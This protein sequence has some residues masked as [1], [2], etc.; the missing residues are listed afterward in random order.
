MDTAKVKTPD[1]FLG[2][3]SS[4]KRKRHTSIACECCR[5]LKVKCLGGEAAALSSGSATPK[6]CNHCVSQSKLC[7]WP[8][9]DGRKKAKT[10]SPA[11]SD[12]SFKSGRRVAGIPEQQ[13]SIPGVP[14]QDSAK[15]ED[16]KTSRSPETSTKFKPPPLAG[17]AK[18]HSSGERSN[19]DASQTPYVVRILLLN[20]NFQ[21]GMGE[22][23]LQARSCGRSGKF[24][25]SRERCC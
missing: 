25:A 14:R 17:N 1:D 7:V 2:P 3:P 16:T 20:D 22:R 12:V 10:S 13:G 4:P 6:P 19:S 24:E 15:S 8:E 23:F 11:G 18:G 21:Y 9:E 5:R